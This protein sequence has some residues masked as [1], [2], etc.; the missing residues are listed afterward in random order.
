[1]G[2][3]EGKVAVAASQARIPLKRVG[4]PRETA[5]SILSLASDAA[6]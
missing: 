4:D 2:E 6:S 1:M 3:E 5:N